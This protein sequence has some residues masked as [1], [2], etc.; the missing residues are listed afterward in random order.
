MKDVKS[1]VG[2]VKSTRLRFKNQKTTK[3]LQRDDVE[4]NQ[5]Q[6][7]TEDEAS[8]QQQY[9]RQPHSN[10]SSHQ[11]DDFIEWGPS[12]M[13]T[14]SLDQSLQRIHYIINKDIHY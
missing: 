8:Q 1:R 10:P 14:D 12:L 13:D 4:P 2:K 5:H 7:E 9:R 3:P 11:K 6:S